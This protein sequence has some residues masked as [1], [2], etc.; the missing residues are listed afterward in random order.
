[1]LLSAV[2]ILVGRVTFTIYSV[3]TLV[4]GLGVSMM[5]HQYFQTAI[6]W[7]YGLA[8][9]QIVISVFLYKKVVAH[10]SFSV[11]RIKLAFNQNYIKNVLF[12]VLNL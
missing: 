4:L 7:L 10:N 12:G 3:S 5:I 9:V 2:N 1:M 8:L 6:G 11:I